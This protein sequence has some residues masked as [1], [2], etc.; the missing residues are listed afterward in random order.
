MGSHYVYVSS[1]E[2][3]QNMSEITIAIIIVTLLVTVLAIFLR[4]RYVAIIYVISNI[5]FFTNAGQAGGWFLLLVQMPALVPS[6]LGMFFGAS[7]GHWIR[8]I[9]G[10]RLSNIGHNASDSLY[11]QTSEHKILP[12]NLDGT[13]KK[14]ENK[15]AVKKESFPDKSA[16]K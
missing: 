1:K 6:I 12:L 4:P 15:Y 13:S 7:I 8:P 3:V 2:G 10:K 16:E 14:R 5:V 9:I 11:K